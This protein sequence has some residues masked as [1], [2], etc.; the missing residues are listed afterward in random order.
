MGRLMDVYPDDRSI[1]E[2]LMDSLIVSCD[3]APRS[4]AAA[5]VEALEEAAGRGEEWAIRMQRACLG[6]GAYEFA[7]E[8]LKADRGSITWTRAGE[9]VSVSVPQRI[10]SRTID[11]ETGSPVGASQQRLWTEMT[12]TEFEAAIG[13]RIE[14][15]DRLSL[16]IVAYRQIVSLRE[17][18]PATATP[19]EACRLAGIDPRDLAS[20]DDLTIAAS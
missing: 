6:Q 4:M 12:W 16:T 3:N 9:I 10:A 8:R 2:T 5:F 17:R 7:R 13:K 15:R 14:Q 1:A 11:P 19:G 18:F 20:L